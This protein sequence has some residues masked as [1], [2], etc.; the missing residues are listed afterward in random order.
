MK[1]EW[2]EGDI[3][4][5]LHIVKPAKGTRAVIG[6]F[7]GTGDKRTVIMEINTDGMVSCQHK[8]DENG[9]LVAGDDD[10]LIPQAF[11]KAEM[12]RYLNS[13]SYPWF[14]MSMF[15]GTG[16]RLKTDSNGRLRQGMEGFKLL[17]KYD[18]GFC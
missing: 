7:G 11:S 1:F 15:T 2:E 14:P 9:D 17:D 13:G 16:V 18:R 6:W 3:V 12:A 10:E 5:G 4:S 8:R